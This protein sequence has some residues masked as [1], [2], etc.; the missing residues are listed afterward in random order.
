MTRFTRDDAFPFLFF[1]FLLAFPRRGAG[2]GRV[3][4]TFARLHRVA[5]GAYQTRKI[6]REPLQGGARAGR[7]RLAGNR[8]QRRDDRRDER[9]R[10]RDALGG[11]GGWRRR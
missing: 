7:E 9:A 10:R 3:A 6:A 5:P 1:R 11:G 2:E 4:E 8:G